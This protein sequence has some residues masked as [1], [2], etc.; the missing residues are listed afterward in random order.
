MLT[1]RWPILL[2]FLGTAAA[3]VQKP[4]PVPYSPTKLDEYDSYCALWRTDATFHSTV[5]LMNS[6][7]NAT[8]DATVTLYMADG[9]PYALPPI[10]MAASEVQTVDVN[11]ALAQAP[12][13]I[14]PH[15]SSFGSASVK[16]RYD[17]AGVVLASMSILD[18]SRSLEYMPSF[19]FAA[20]A[21]PASGGGAPPPQAYDG[22][23][24][25][26]S[27]SSA[28]FVAL[29]NTTD[30]SIGVEFGISGLT[31]PAGTS[32]TLAPH[33]T[34]MLNLNA[35][36]TGDPGMVGGL[37]IAY[38]GNLGAVQVVGG[39][40]DATKGFSVDMPIASQVAPPDA[41]GPRELA[42]VGIMVNQQDPL[43]N[44]PASVSFT[45]YAF[46]RNVSNSPK[47][48]SLVVYYMDGRTP[49]SLS[50]PDL[51]LQPGQAQELSIG[52]L[53][54]KQ[55]QI[56]DINLA[57]SYSGY[58]SDILAGIG[59]TDQTGNYVFPVIPAVAYRGGARVSPYWLAAGGFD[60]MYTVWNP[61]ADAQE[62][63]LTLK[64]GSNGE[65]Y[66]LPLTLEAYAS[67]MIDMGELIRTRQ[68]D[69]NGS[70]LPPD[71]QQ[72]SFVVGS[73]TELVGD[74]VNVVVGMGIY[75]PTKATCGSGTL[76]CNGMVTPPGPEV[77]PASVTLGVGGTQQFQLV[78]WDNSNDEDNDTAVW[79]STNSSVL[80]IGT[81]SGLA[82]ATG[83]GEATVNAQTN[84]QSN[85]VP[86]YAV[87]NW[88]GQQPTC[89]MTSISGGAN[90]TVQPTI[91]YNGKV[92]SGSSNATNVVVGQ[93]ISLTGTPAGGTWDI[94]GTTYGQFNP[95]NTGNGL[96]EVN[97]STNPVSFFW[98]AGGN[99]TVSYTVSGQPA[100]ATFNVA[101][102]TGSAGVTLC[103]PVSVGD[104][105]I[106]LGIAWNSTVTP[107][108]GFSG[109][110]TWYQVINSINLTFLNSGGGLVAT[111]QVNPTP[112]YPAIDGAIP[113]P[114]QNEGGM[115]D[116]PAI[117]LPAN[118][119]Q[120]VATIRQ[121]QSFTSYLLWQPTGVG[122]SFP[123]P[124]AYM[125]WGW[126]GNAVWQNGAW[127]LGGGS[128]DSC[129][130]G[131][132]SP[133]YPS[134]SSL[135]AAHPVY[136]CE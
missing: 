124:L 32:L 89:P 80:S 74:A 95:T 78:Y 103:G 5:R 45:P 88:S 126:T 68:L 129:A 108:S 132:G 72:G 21:A 125:Q 83:V 128:S 50:L 60:T 3:Q 64:Y 48:L 44:F 135:I 47:T 36:F 31:S 114:F 14:Q 33:G 25:R 28:G 122:T 24:W 76:Y 73:P 111:C 109:S 23:W 104:G 130:V 51:T 120:N 87:I 100:S 70:L 17:W 136:Q 19:R 107:P 15:L 58:L 30:Q 61:E 41:A 38:G 22:L 123:V 34:S 20:T 121:V 96:A 115:Q 63:L 127:S 131:Q 98:V 62:L 82:T 94:G 133:F 116:S 118:P 1:L 54:S 35:F 105:E 81:S 49:K 2:L 112:T 52:S 84:G 101:A 71:A 40:E 59:S 12:P 13:A 37:H 7:A 102:P 113:Y 29:A 85:Q 26:Y 18:T 42:A 56:Q 99:Q 66:K 75:N 57:Y 43:L 46:F 65:S 134:W 6:L 86:V 106:G 79:G 97:T 9:T 4:T 90:V 8:I 92:I 91:S 10:H 39:L 77:L 69:Q 27:S 117:P 55:T 67:T 119:P 11:A 53:M 16:Y 93:Q 110:V